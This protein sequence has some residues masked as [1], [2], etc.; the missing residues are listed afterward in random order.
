MKWLFTVH[1]FQDIKC[2]LNISASSCSLLQW[3]WCWQT[4]WKWG[5]PFIANG[6]AIC[7]AAPWSYLDGDVRRRNYTGPAECFNQHALAVLRKHQDIAVN[8]SGVVPSRGATAEISLRKTE[9]GNTGFLHEDSRAGWPW[10]CRRQTADR[11]TVRKEEDRR[12]GGTDWRSQG[13]PRMQG[14]ISPITNQGSRLNTGCRRLIGQQGKG[15]GVAEVE[16]DPWLRLGVPIADLT[17]YPD[18]IWARISDWILVESKTTRDTAIPTSLGRQGCCPLQ[19]GQIVLLFFVSGILD[20]QDGS[21]RLGQPWRR[22]S[23]K[24]VWSLTHGVG[25]SSFKPVGSLWRRQ[26]CLQG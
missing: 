7:H 18:V 2:D 3:Q 16:S 8:T 14:L 26:T 9:T 12:C 13:G 1:G 17:G 15:T 22:Q 23:A 5:E 20:I 19:A 4:N 6:I 25:T 10:G 11:P 21:G 24:V